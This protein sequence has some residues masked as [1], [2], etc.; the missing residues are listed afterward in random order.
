MND[1]RAKREVTNI[2]SGC[3]VV[4]RGKRFFAEKILKINC[5]WPVSSMLRVPMNLSVQSSVKN[6]GES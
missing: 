1:G 4:F 6:L 3:I 2:L 5:Q